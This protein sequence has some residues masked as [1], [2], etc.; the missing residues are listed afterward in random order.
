[1]WRRDVATLL[2]IVASLFLVSIMPAGAQNRPQGVFLAT[3]HELP[4][5]DMVAGADTGGADAEA[6]LMAPHVLRA[7][8]LFDDTL[9]SSPSYVAGPTKPMYECEAAPSL[10]TEGGQLVW[11]R[12]GDPT[13][14][15]TIELE[16]DAPPVSVP[17]DGWFPIVR[18]RLDGLAG[19]GL[20]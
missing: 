16:D 15:L 4:R 13:E 20:S 12:A 1:M 17:S 6:R 3:A 2:I 9:T 5:E 14:H 10:L 18:I 7:R 11:A 19:T 8:I